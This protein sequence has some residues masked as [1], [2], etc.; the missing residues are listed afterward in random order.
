MRFDGEVNLIDRAKDFVDFAYS[1]LY[2]LSV[3]VCAFVL[4]TTDLVFEVD[5][6]VKKWNF[7]VDGFANHFTF[8]CVYKGAQLC[9]KS[10]LKFS[11][12][13]SHHT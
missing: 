6:S 9:L 5:G 4:R 12:K 13:V 3:T 2:N 11:F 1:S 7:W 10:A 8:A